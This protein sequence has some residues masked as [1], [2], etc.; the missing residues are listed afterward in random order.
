VFVA[1]WSKDEW[2]KKNL[3]DDQELADQMEIE[4]VDFDSLVPDKPVQPEPREDDNGG[5]ARS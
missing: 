5:P 4:A 3:G 1:V 2:L